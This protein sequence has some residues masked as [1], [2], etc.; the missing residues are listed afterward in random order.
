[1]SSIINDKAL[2]FSRIF[3]EKKQLALYGVKNIGLFGSFVRGGT[4]T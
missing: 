1:M 2:I 4:N 3:D